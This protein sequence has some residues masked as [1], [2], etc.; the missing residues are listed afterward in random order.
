MRT[1]I[2][3]PKFQG[4]KIFRFNFLIM[5][6]YLETELIIVFQGIVLQADIAL[7]L[8]GVTLLMHKHK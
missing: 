6:L 4:K 7:L 2:L 8:P 3:G 5:Y 1:H